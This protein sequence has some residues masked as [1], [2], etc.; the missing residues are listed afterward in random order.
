MKIW[1]LK[2]ILNKNWKLLI[3]QNTKIWQNF[4]INYNIYLQNIIIKYNN[5]IEI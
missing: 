3:Q 1:C 2:N 5:F 4:N